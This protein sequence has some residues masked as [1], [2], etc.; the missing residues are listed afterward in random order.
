MA[1]SCQKVSE[2]G[3]A[4]MS[5][6][7]PLRQA[8]RASIYSCFISEAFNLGKDMSAQPMVCYNKQNLRGKSHAHTF[9]GFFSPL[10]AACARTHAAS[11][12]QP[13]DV[14]FHGIDHSL[15][16]SNEFDDT[17]YL[18]EIDDEGSSILFTKARIYLMVLSNYVDVVL[19]QNI[20]FK[21]GNIL[22]TL[23]R[24]A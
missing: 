1:F 4:R 24:V 7:D 15:A 11:Q 16:V 3:C 13:A 21:K 23:T 18:H 17:L 9:F 6:H 14:Y 8:K 10:P 2:R 22:F 20:P 12:I 19:G 5:M